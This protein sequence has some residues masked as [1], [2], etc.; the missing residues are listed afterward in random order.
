MGCA[1]RDLLGRSCNTSS[2]IA[3]YPPFVDMLNEMLL[4]FRKESRDNELRDEDIIFAVN[5]P[6][7][8]E[9]THLDKSTKRK[10]DLIC[11]FAKK[12]RSLQE[13]CEDYNFLDCVCAVTKPKSKKLNSKDK[14]TWGDVLHSWELKS[15]GTIKLQIPEDFEAKEI[16]DR[17]E[18]ETLTS[19]GNI[20]E[21]SAASTSQGK[22]QLLS[23]TDII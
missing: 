23:L 5:D 13:D 12:F 10:P 22:C 11:L 20:Y 2:E 7:V 3:R 18:Q 1:Y 16:L 9:S 17:E 15:T 4:H 21:T 14:A 6:V 19:S 8:I